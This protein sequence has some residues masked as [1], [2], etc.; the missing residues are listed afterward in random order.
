VQP[1]IRDVK[2]Y[3]R[4]SKNIGVKIEK[5]KKK[6]RCL[7]KIANCVVTLLYFFY[8]QVC[9]FFQVY[10]GFRVLFEVCNISQTVA[11]QSKKLLV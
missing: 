3:Y 2:A 4:A 7:A 5:Y 6:L 1:C 8:V 11:T 9:I 10:F